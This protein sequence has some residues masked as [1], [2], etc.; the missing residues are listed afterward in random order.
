[1]RIVEEVSGWTRTHE[2]SDLEGVR[3]ALWA[4]YWHLRNIGKNQAA[5]NL[6]K[7]IENTKPKRK[8]F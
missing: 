8:A 2:K 4:V 5:L 1:M 3:K 7:R 6:L